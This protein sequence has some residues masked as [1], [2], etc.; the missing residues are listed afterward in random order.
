M[1]VINERTEGWVAGLQL[2]ALSL[3]GWD[4]PPTISKIIN[5]FSGQQPNVLYYLTDEV[6]TYQPI[7]VQEFLLAT[8]ILERTNADLCD[9]VTGQ[10]N[11]QAMLE[12]LDASNF[13][14]LVIDEQ[15]KWYRYYHIFADLPTLSAKTFIQ[16]ASL[17]YI[18]V[19][20]TGMSNTE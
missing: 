9:A 14:L 10:N 16:I 17:N 13:F 18:Y 3:Q 4:D 19:P 11:G 12:R 15:E 5:A 1:L 20:V 2:A 8:S 6:L 7:E